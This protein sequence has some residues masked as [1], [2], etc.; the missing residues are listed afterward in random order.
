MCID[1]KDLDSLKRFIMK[2]PYVKAL[3]LEFGKGI[4]VYRWNK[5]PHHLLRADD[6]RHGVPH[7]CLAKYQNEGR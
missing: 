7:F 5:D 2:E 1:A 4:D 6:G 3:G